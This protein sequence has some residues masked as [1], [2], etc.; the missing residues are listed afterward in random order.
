MKRLSDDERNFAMRTLLIA[1]AAM[2]FTAM[3]AHA[4]LLG[5]GGLG[6]GLGGT[7]GG[8]LGGTLNGGPL[9]STMDSV[10]G[11]ATGSVRGS[12]SA[13]AHKSVDRKSGK[14]HADGAGSGSLT[15]N[16]A[17]NLT[18]AT[19]PL[20]GNVSGTA[21]GRA[22]GKGSA[23]ADGQLIGTDAVRN[24][25]ASAKGMAMGASDTALT[26]TGSAVDT[27]SGTASATGNL[28][29]SAAANGSGAAQGAASNLALAGSIASSA[30][31]A[32]SVS[33]GM[34][35]NAPDGSRIGTVRKV[36]S[37]ARGNVQSLVVKAKGETATLPA[38][39]FTA[40]GNALV[41]AAGRGEIGKPVNAQPGSGAA[42]AAKPAKEQ[43][44]A[45]GKDTR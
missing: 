7:L 12:G 29:G 27:L 21:T 19:A 36:I 24:S 26:A 3:P 11:T 44:K 42:K 10:E 34:P 4:Q 33:K 30:D 38:G 17:G 40:S 9:G 20:A 25:T 2:L 1:S 45:D 41:S 8:S 18:S 23:S 22:K 28:A 39:N 6:G 15:G 5:G 31:G 37:D 16:A 43:A 14:V 35:V 13:S 32:F